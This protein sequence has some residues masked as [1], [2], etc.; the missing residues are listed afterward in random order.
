MSILPELLA[1]NEEYAAGFTNGDLSPRPVRRLAI[2][3][4]MDCRI[5]PFKMLGLSEGDAHVIRN[6]GARATPDAIRSLILSH[7][8]L[9]TCEFIVIHHTGCGMQRVTNEEL[10]ADLQNSYGVD[11]NGLDFLPIT[12]PL[13]SLRDD[14][15]TIHNSP[16]IPDSIPVT[17]L[18][19]DVTTGRL[20]RVT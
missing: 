2:L 3:T 14:V 16:F 19:F 8:V 6:A 12:D 10:W 5:V 13:Q 15:A 18:I 7:K 11:A 4:C 20:E 9:G 1:A 17:G